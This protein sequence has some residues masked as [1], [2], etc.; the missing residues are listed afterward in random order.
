MLICNFFIDF[1]RAYERVLQVVVLATDHIAINFVCA[2][3][4]SV[5]KVCIILCHV[6]KISN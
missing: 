3:K 2:Y 5:Y 1:L 6:C 4:Y